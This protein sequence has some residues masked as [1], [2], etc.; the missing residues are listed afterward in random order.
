LKNIFDLKSKMSEDCCNKCPND[1]DDDDSSCCSHD[2][3]SSCCSHDDDSSCCSHDDSS[4]KIKQLNDTEIYFQF[5][6]KIC[7]LFCSRFFIATNKEL[8]N[9]ILYINNNESI[10]NIYAKCENLEKLNSHTLNVKNFKELNKN[11]IEF[12]KEEKFEIKSLSD[13]IRLNINLKNEP[14]DINK[15]LIKQ[16]NET[17]IC[18]YLINED[19]ETFCG[20]T[21]INN[22]KTN[23]YRNYRCNNCI[24]Y[25]IVRSI[26]PEMNPNI[27]IEVK[28]AGKKI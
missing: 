8:K 19:E 25:C 22:H 1:S 4:N 12:A 13:L 6:D 18:A 15:F 21:A 5:N 3:D 11:E 7:S 20:K 24:E 26:L 9:C 17:N 28:S 14:L 16:S 10:Y 2:D 23:D 27:K